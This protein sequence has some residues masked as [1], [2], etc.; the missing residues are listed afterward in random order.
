MSENRKKLVI[1]IAGYENEIKEGFFKVNQGLARRFP[2]RYV[3][4][5][6]KKEELKDIFIRMIRISDDTYLYKAPKQELDLNKLVVDKTVTIKSLDK[7]VTDEDIID[8]FSDMRY[9]NNCGGDIENLITHISFANNERSIGKH[10]SMRNIFTKQDLIRG[11]EMFK[12]HKT[13]NED[14]KWKKMFN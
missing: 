1:I 6:Y 9:F 5:E 3:L 4:K 11:L 10:P 7:T 13:E 12:Y 2:F 8:L 14:D